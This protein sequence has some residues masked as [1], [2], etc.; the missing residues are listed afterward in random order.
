MWLTHHLHTPWACPV[1]FFPWAPCSPCCCCIRPHMTSVCPPSL[2]RPSHPPH[3]TCSTCCCRILSGEVDQAEQRYLE[4]E[5][6][7]KGF[8]LI[9]VSC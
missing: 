3:S 6:M 4:E 9:C 1:T 7:N 5:E 2:P 8:A